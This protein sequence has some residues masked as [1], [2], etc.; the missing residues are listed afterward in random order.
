MRKSLA[1]ALVFALSACGRGASPTPTPALPSPTRPA[2]SPTPTPSPASSPAPSPTPSPAPFLPL[3]PEE[4]RGPEPTLGPGQ[5]ALAVLEGFAPGSPLTIR[6]V[7][8]ARGV[9]VEAPG[10]ADAAGSY[11]VAHLVRMKPSDPGARPEGRLWFEAT[12]GKVV[13]RHPF[14]IDYARSVPPAPAACGFYPPAPRRDASVAA[15]CGGFSGRSAVAV[16]I[17]AGGKEIGR[18]AAVFDPAAAGN[19]LDASGTAFVFFRIG[20]DEPEGE[21][22]LDFDGRSVRFPVR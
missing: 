3:V 2:A 11:L 1:L 21:W 12:D 4:G 5:L 19:I 14:R 17:R 10:R 9:L 16:R 22:I 13:K 15:W 7:H 6:L 20:P 8:E 18:R